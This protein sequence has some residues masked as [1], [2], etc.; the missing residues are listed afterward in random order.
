M[1]RIHPLKWTSQCFWHACQVGQPSPLSKSTRSQAPKGDLSPLARAPP[2]PGAHRFIVWLWTCHRNGLAWC[3]ASVTSLSGWASCSQVHLC[4]GVSSWYLFV[5]GGFPARAGGLLGGSNFLAALN[6]ATG[7]SAQASI[8]T[9]VFSSWGTR[10]GVELLCVTSGSNTTLFP[11]LPRP[12]T[13]PPAG[14]RSHFS[15]SSPTL[16]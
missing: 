11:W 2:V 15:T 13:S 16:S 1:H 4:S 3:V 12:L 8:W 9:D 6:N 7:T 5:A 10:L 14:V